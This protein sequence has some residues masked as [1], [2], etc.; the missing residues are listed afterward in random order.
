[1]Y[2]FCVREII[3][4]YCIWIIIETS[5]LSDRFIYTAYTSQPLTFTVRSLAS[6][7]LEFSEKKSSYLSF[8]AVDFNEEFSGMSGEIMARQTRFTNQCL[9]TIFKLYENHRNP[10]DSIAII[11]HSMVCSFR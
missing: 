9:K 1:M 6:I 4:I 2:Y 5:S 7:S 10:P 8:F 3:S 11:A